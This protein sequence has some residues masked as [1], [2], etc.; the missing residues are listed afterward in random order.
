MCADRWA[1]A[2]GLTI[3][4]MPAVWRKD[5]G[6]VD[7]TAGPRRNRAMLALS[8]ATRDAAPCPIA[9][10]AFSGGDGTEGMVKQAQAARVPVWRAA[11]AGWVRDVG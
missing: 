8:C 9:V 11:E 3:T 7:R 10:L 1:R 5:G 2:R 6:P 4:P